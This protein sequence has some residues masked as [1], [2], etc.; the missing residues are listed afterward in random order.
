MLDLFSVTALEAILHLL[1][2]FD[3][4]ERMLWADDELLV[5]FPYLS[6]FAVLVMFGGSNRVA[7]TSIGHLWVRQF[8]TAARRS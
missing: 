7:N 8:K 2:E 1:Q 6:S 5:T 4:V 3:Q